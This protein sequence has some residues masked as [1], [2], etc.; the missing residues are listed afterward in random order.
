MV[1]TGFIEATDKIVLAGE[2]I[3][4]EKTIET[5]A[6]MY[7]GRLVKMDTGAYQIEVN[8]TDDNVLGWLGYE[9]TAVMYRPTTKDT[10]YV[11]NDK[12]HIIIGGDIVIRARLASGDNVTAIGTK[13][14]A[15]A[16]GE[17]TAATIGTHMVLAVALEIVNASSAAANIIVKSRL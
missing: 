8:D 11:V 6:N 12:A 10:I 3:T 17:L 9:Q 5:V 14:T 1:D 13:L 2:P 4:V 15:T 7:P 16:D